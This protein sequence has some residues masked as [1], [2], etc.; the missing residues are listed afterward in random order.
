MKTYGTNDQSNYK[1]IKIT[2]DE[3]DN[4]HFFAAI[5]AVCFV[6]CNNDE[7]FILDNEVPAEEIVT[8]ERVFSADRSAA[9]LQ[10]F[11]HALYAA[12]N[13]SQMLR[14]I[15]RTKALKRFNK[16]YDVLYQFIKNEPVENGLTVRQLLLKHF[17]S[18]EILTAIETSRPTLTI[19]VPRLPNETFSAEVWNTEKDIPRV[20]LHT[21]HV[22]TPIIGYFGEYGNEFLLEAGFIPAFPV[23]ALRDNAR[24]RVVQGTPSTRS[25]TLDNAGSSFVFEFV[26]DFYDNSKR[27]EEKLSTRLWSLQQIDPRLQR[28]FEIFPND[29]AGWQRDYIYYGLTPTNT[30]GRL[31][32]DFQ[33]HITS[34]RFSGSHHTPAQV[35]REL[36]QHSGDP[37]LVGS[38]SNRP[39]RHWTNGHYTFIADVQVAS[40]AALI[41]SLKRRFLICPS[42]L[43]TTYYVRVRR[44]IFTTVY[45]VRLDN[46]PNSFRVRYLSIPL[47]NWCLEQF[48][49]TMRIS[50]AKYNPGLTETITNTV[51]SEFAGNVGINVGAPEW[52]VGLQFGASGRIQRTATIQTVRSLTN[53]QLG[54]VLVNFGDMVVLDKIALPPGLFFFPFPPFREFRE[55]CSGFFAITVKP[56]R[57]Q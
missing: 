42:Y 38:S 12:M 43:F 57:V 39:N 46:N 41:P 23:V 53:R 44:N 28:A 32:R 9:M 34:F 24:V 21:R 2:K 1:K 8:L 22:Y 36:T 15:I 33:E 14:E 40:T 11:A 13:E 37:R 55:Y 26:D 10:P 31:S 51:V 7:I 17:E 6:A 54:D 4:N 49:P 25:T 5:I 19:F 30:T 52:K 27:E 47:M 56:R 35:L 18:E 48:A 16:E 50:I 45:E 3:K 20:A 29:A